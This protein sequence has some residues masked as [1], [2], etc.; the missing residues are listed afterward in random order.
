MHSQESHSTPG[1]PPSADLESY[2]GSQIWRLWAFFLSLVHPERSEGSLRTSMHSQE[3]HSTPGYP[4]L[5][6]WNRTLDRKFASFGHSSCG[7][8][9]ENACQENALLRCGSVSGASHREIG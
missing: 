5:P 4:L 2:F 8:L 1:Y 3:S 6:T 7:K 9:N